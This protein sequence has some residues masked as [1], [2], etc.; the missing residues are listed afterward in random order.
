M[1]SLSNKN[2]PDISSIC[3]LPSGYLERVILESTCGKGSNLH[4]SMCLNRGA[5]APLTLHLSST[6]TWTRNKF[7]GVWGIMY[8]LVFLLTATMPPIL[9]ISLLMQLVYCNIGT[10]EKVAET[11]V[12]K[13]NHVLY[14]IKMSYPFFSQK[15]RIMILRWSRRK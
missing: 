15:Y 14:N 5:L 8:L 3:F 10:Y 11:R 6:V 7:H 1:S 12:E 9:W 13:I 2:L 4:Q